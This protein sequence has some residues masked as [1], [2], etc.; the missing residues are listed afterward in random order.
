MMGNRKSKV[1]DPANVE[2][3]RVRRTDEHVRALYGLLDQRAHGISH[4]AMPTFEQHREFVLAHP[5]R[6]WY[7]I[8]VDGKPVGTIYL[9]RSNNV[10]VSV[11]PGAARYLPEAIRQIVRRHK[12]LPPIKSVRAAGYILNVSPENTE[13]ISVLEEMHAELLQLTYG[14]DVASIFL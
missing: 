4:R 10:G 7:L 2:L 11:A 5:Y 9:L 3:V 13:L 12:P 14:I 6:A 8:Q 1:P